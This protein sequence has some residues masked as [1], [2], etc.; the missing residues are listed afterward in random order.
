M[1]GNVICGKWGGLW[2]TGV[3]QGHWKYCHSIQC[4]RVPTSHSQ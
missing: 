4:I 2:L 1:K 3:T